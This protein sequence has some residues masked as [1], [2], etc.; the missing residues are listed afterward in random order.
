MLADSSRLQ[1][2][3]GY[4]GRLLATQ[5]RVGYGYAQTFASSE[6]RQGLLYGAQLGLNLGKV[7]PLVE[8]DGVSFNDRGDQV[9]ILPGLQFL[10]ASL[11][12]MQLG[13]SGLIGLTFDDSTL[14]NR[15]GAVIEASYNFL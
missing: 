9:T 2:M 1:A 5:L 6:L 4:G 12:T 15:Y 11:P 13:V 8:V 7:Q 3:W 10:P 14:S